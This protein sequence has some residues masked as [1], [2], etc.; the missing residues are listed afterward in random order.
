M[1]NDERYAHASLPGRTLFPDEQMPH[2]ITESV[3]GLVIARPSA[4]AN[5]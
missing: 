3:M 5:S 1:N 4:T 2:G